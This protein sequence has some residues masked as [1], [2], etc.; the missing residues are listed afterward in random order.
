MPAK[1]C[2][3]FRTNRLLIYTNR[4]ICGC[5]RICSLL[6]ISPHLFSTAILCGVGS[7]C[8]IPPALEA[9]HLSAVMLFQEHC[10][11]VALFSVGQSEDLKWRWF[12]HQCSKNCLPKSLKKVPNN[13]MARRQLW[14]ISLRVWYSFARTM[15]NRLFIVNF[16]IFVGLNR[17]VCNIALSSTHSYIVLYCFFRCYFQRVIFRYWNFRAHNF[18]QLYS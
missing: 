2:H 3:G 16:R 17:H 5:S 12:R 15:A 1:T 4:V 7:L 6:W 8:V 13:W 18:G 9:R 11:V 14:K 10:V